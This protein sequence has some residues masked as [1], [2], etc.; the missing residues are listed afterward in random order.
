MFWQIAGWLSWPSEKNWRPLMHALWNPDSLYQL[1]I[2]VLEFMSIQLLWGKDGQRM[3]I[4]NLFLFIGNF[5]YMYAFQGQIFFGKSSIL[6]RAFLGCSKAEFLFFTGKSENIMISRKK[7][8]NF[9]MFGITY[10]YLHLR[11][12]NLLQKL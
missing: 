4:S 8:K 7:R 9:D 6:L 12:G 11:I 1:A 3:L 5:I 10:C 2:Q